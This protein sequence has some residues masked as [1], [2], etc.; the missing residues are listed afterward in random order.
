MLVFLG[1]REWG[2]ETEGGRERERERERL[3]RGSRRA[4]LQK[5][6]ATAFNK[7][8]VICLDHTPIFNQVWF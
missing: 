3:T 4:V 2:W 5:K 1:K 7:G 8:H 6:V